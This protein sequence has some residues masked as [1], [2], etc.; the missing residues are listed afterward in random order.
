MQN[1]HS[2][3][4]QPSSISMKQ[5]DKRRGKFKVSDEIIVFFTYESIYTFSP[6]ISARFKDYFLGLS[7]CLFW[8]VNKSWELTAVVCRETRR[9]HRK[10]KWS[11]T[12]TF[13]VAFSHRWSCSLLYFWM[14]RKQF[15]RKC[16]IYSSAEFVPI[17]LGRFKRS[18]ILFVNLR[19]QF[20]IS[21]DVNALQSVRRRINHALNI[22]TCKFFFLFV[23]F[24]IN[25]RFHFEAN[26]HRTA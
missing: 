10:V 1:F 3:Y 5:R 8:K 20:S 24:F 17:F 21:S 11:T 22:E 12:N 19:G 4:L 16:H 26:K 2:R 15:T 25:V 23:F 14:N 13:A 6:S 9:V 7:V 18:E